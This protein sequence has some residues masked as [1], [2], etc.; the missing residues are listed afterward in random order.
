MAIVLPGPTH[1]CRRS[2]AYTVVLLAK[3]TLTLSTMGG[4]HKPP[5][6]KSRPG[7]KPLK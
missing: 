6:D 2:K 5:P 1:L 3:I 4:R 7:Q